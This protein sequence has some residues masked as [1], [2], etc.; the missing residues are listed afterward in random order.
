M[1]LFASAFAGAFN[2][3]RSPLFPRGAAIL[4]W[5]FAAAVIFVILSTAV[6]PRYG[7]IARESRED[8]LKFV[9]KSY[10]KAIM[11]YKRTYGTGPR[12]LAE[13][14]KQQPNPRF[15]RALYDDPF[16]TKEVEVRNRANGIVTIADPSGE[17]VNVKSGSDEKSISGVAYCRWF[18]NSS[19]VFQVEGTY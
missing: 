11:K 1:T 10:K 12:A 4:S 18:Y 17:I 14:V 19:L 9:L 13:L 16:F 2:V 5:V 8:E 6:F 3:P 7:T 15:I